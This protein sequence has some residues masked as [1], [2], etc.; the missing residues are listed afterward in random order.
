[1]PHYKFEGDVIRLNQKDFDDWQKMYPSLDLAHELSQMDLE[2]KIRR[3]GGEH[4]K[5]WFPE[6][7]K[8]LN[9]RNIYAKKNGANT[10][11]TSTRD[12][13]L[14]QELNDTSWANRSD[15]KKNDYNLK[16]L[17]DDLPF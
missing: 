13:T 16:N 12:M 8:R 14:E 5:K 17:D 2:F 4:L 3:E 11:H 15:I 6:A 9:T 7:Y 10:R 1:M